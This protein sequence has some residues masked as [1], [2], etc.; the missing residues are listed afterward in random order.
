[1]YIVYIALYNLPL[2]LSGPVRFYLYPNPLIYVII[3]VIDNRY[4]PRKGKGVSHYE[5]IDK[6]FV[7]WPGLIN[8]L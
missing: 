6:C 7:F 3:S 4:S 5:Y 2:F 8:R 1:M